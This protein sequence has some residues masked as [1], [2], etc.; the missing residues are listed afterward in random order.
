MGIGSEVQVSE[1]VIDSCF[2]L[3]KFIFYLKD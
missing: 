3:E 1:A 2:R